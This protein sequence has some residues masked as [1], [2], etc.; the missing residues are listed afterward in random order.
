L[1]GRIINDID[2]FLLGHDDIVELLLKNKA[3]VDACDINDWTPLHE[4]ARCSTHP[5]DNI[6]RT[7]CIK[8][9]VKVGTA[10][11]DALNIRRDTPL[12][13][14]CE[15]GSSQLATCLLELGAEILATN[16]DGYN[17]LEVAIEHN[18]EE[19]VK[20]LLEDDNAFDLMRNAQVTEKKSELLHRFVTH[21]EAD[22]PMRKLIRK[23]PKMAL[24]MLDKCTMTVGTDR[25]DVHKQVY[26]YEFLDDQYT[27][28][29]WHEGKCNQLISIL[30]L[31]NSESKS[32]FFLCR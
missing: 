5:E 2:F 11:V 22:T 17:C 13:I 14:A 6:K 21:Y 15:Y 12:H 27:I 20:F 30:L 3:D 32:N 29:D 19:V 4:A 28:K 8:L 26:I 25:T 16:V 9:L 24:R 10:H 1:F 18:N 23:M 31:L 7:Q